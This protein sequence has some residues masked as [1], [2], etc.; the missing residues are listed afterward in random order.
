MP[1]K[2]KAL[3]IDEAAFERYQ[4]FKFKM[5]TNA[6]TTSGISATVTDSALITAL[7]EAYESK[8]EQTRND[9]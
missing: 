3:R 6:K 1:K 4:E 9:R 2:F 7:I 8:Q 5:L